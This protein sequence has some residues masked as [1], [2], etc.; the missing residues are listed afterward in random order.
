M[1]TNHDNPYKAPRHVERP[2]TRF[3]VKKPPVGWLVFALIWV[4]AMVILLTS[5]QVLPL[6]ARLILTLISFVALFGLVQSMT[7]EG[8]LVVPGIL[9]L[10]VLLVVVGI[11]IHPYWTAAQYHEARRRR[12]SDSTYGKKG[13]I[14]WM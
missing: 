11:W 5:V 8:N 10:I 9:L 7:L 4:I 3:P 6:F 2:N 1:S 14:N 12:I 13:K